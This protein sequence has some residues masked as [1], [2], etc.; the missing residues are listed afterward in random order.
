MCK[1]CIEKS[2]CFPGCQKCV[3]VIQKVC[4]F[5][6]LACFGHYFCGELGPSL[7][8]FCFI[9][10]IREVYVLCM[11]IALNRKSLIHLLLCPWL[12]NESTF[13]K[14]MWPKLSNTRFFKKAIEGSEILL[15]TSFPLYVFCFYPTDQYR[16]EVRLNTFPLHLAFHCNFPNPPFRPLKLR[17]RHIFL[18]GF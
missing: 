17:R 15:A 14:S 11:S 18:F 7:S 8:H 6:I 1:R 12:V 13:L 16:Y 3:C 5:D 4:N 9:D 2:R 10:V